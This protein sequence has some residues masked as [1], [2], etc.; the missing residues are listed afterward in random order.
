MENPPTRLLSGFLFEE[1]TTLCEENDA[2][3][4]VRGKDGEEACSYEK[5]IDPGLSV[6]EV[7]TVTGPAK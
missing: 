5:K 1:V 2:N 3:C 6:P 7:V 4:C